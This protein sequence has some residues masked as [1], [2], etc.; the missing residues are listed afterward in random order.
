MSFF[1]ILKRDPMKKTT[2]TKNNTTTFCKFYLKQRVYYH[3]FET[4]KKRKI[5]KIKNPKRKQKAP[6]QLTKQNKTNKQTNKTKTFKKT[7]TNKRPPTKKTKEKI[8]EIKTERK[9]P[10]KKQHLLPD[11]SYL[12]TINNTIFTSLTYTCFSLIDIEIKTANKQAKK[13]NLNG[14]CYNECSL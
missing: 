6:I 5:K 1:M 12:Q 13:Q 14:N 4:R 3:R 7:H 9:K 10:Y 8:N 11:Y 2:K